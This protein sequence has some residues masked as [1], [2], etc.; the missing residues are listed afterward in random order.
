MKSFNLYVLILKRDYQSKFFVTRN[1]PFYKWTVYIKTLKHRKFWS[2]FYITC[3]RRRYWFK[4]GYSWNRCSKHYCFSCHFSIYRPRLF[5][6]FIRRTKSNYRKR[7]SRCRRQIIWSRK[8]FKRSA[9]TI[10]SSKRCN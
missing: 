10:K 3:R 4:S 9:K 1:F 2:N 7:R 6:I 8:T 5:R